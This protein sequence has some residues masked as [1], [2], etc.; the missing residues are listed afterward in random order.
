MPQTVADI[1]WPTVGEKTR[2]PG[3]TRHA[4]LFLLFG[5]A[6]ILF[7]LL[8]LSIGY[9]R[10]P[11]SEVVKIVTG[12]TPEHASWRDI[13]LVLRM[14][15]AVTAIFASAALA[16]GGLMM[17]TLF[18]NPLAGPW[19][20]GIT[21]GARLGV[22]VI[23]FLNGATF[24]AIPVGRLARLGDVS[25][26]TGAC[27]GASGILALI[28]VIARRVNAI[29]LLIVGLMFQY[30]APAIDGVLAH[31]TPED[32]RE[33]FK[34]WFFAEFG[35]TTW[36][37]LQIMVPIIVV[38]AAVAVLLAKSLNALLMGEN[39]A[40]SVGE[41]VSRTRLIALGSM[42]GL[43]GIVTAFCGPVSF[44]DLAIPHLCRGIFRTSDHRVLMPAVL[45]TGGLVGLAA[46]FVLHLPWKQH[47]F[48]LDYITALIG[49]PVIL[50]LVL[51]SRQMKEIM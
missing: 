13:V 10:V 19:V 45:V 32:Q 23:L 43:S 36:Q 44:L 16:A 38:S 49:A 42:I 50:W 2:A 6:I 3:A 9:A 34:M 18:R 41:N 24:N 48:H 11:M 35:Q 33:T 39:Y 12:G 27:L 8:E 46:D 37:Q 5:A 25:L 17:Q 20:L 30:L 40:R 7:F 31:M 15:R 1:V 21:A 51:R 14:P 26:A 29:T 28:A 47:V 22:S 4:L